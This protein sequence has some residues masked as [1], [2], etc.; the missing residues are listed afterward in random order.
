M[1]PIIPIEQIEKKIFIL[2]GMKI[3]VDS[4]LSIL[5]GVQV[6]ALVRA[7]K[8][9]SDRFPLDFCF[10]LTKEEFAAMKCQFGISDKG[11]GGRRFMP[12][13]FSQEGVAMLSSVLRSQRAAIINVTIMRAF[14]KLREMMSTHKDLAK[15]LEEL[16]VKLRKHDSKFKKHA[17]KIKM[18]FDAIW[19]IMNL[20][21]P[22]I[23]F[24][25]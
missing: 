5:Y 18:V 15:K 2:R 19:E 11:R 10:Q 12:Y 23:G 14:V 25:N 13:A 20:P 21:K 1:L 16:E 4:D 24:T 6:G 9:N 3:M 22:T 7:V 17:A 8:R